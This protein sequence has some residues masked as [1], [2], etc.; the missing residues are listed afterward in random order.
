MGL[1]AVDAVH[2]DR[3]G[4]GEVLG[5]IPQAR[6]DR[7][8]LTCGVDHEDGRLDSRH[9]GVGIADEVRVAGGVDDVKPR[10]VPRHRG[11]GEFDRE[12]ALLLLGVVVERG[13]GALVAAQAPGDAREVEH[14]LG[15][16]RLAH[17]ALA[18]EGDVPDLL[19]HGD[20]LRLGWARPRAGAAAQPA[21]ARALLGPRYPRGAIR[22]PHPV[23]QPVERGKRFGMRLCG[24]SGMRRRSHADV[25]VF[26]HNPPPSRPIS[27]KTTELDDGRPPGSFGT[28][29]AYRT[30]RWP[31]GTLGIPYKSRSRRKNGK[32]L[33]SAGEKRSMG[34]PYTLMRDSRRRSAI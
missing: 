28:R 27:S 4:E 20:S 7:A 17:A 13:L 23:K 18:H 16:H 14:G 19:A 25:G 32:S 22:G 24:R 12:G 15:E 8:R 1:G 11:H 2:E 34:T 5:G 10:A 29:G 6:G 30:M 33:A 9:G 31:P 3:T 26:G 21:C